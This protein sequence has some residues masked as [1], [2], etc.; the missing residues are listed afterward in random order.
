MKFT[1]PAP[2]VSLSSHPHLE[3]MIASIDMTPITF[4]KRNAFEQTLLSLKHSNNRHITNK[5]GS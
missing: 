2:S 5:M 1:I 4:K 3:A